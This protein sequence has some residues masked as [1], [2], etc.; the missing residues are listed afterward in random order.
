MRAE[1]KS[2]APTAG[3]RLDS[4]LVLLCEDLVASPGGLNLGLLEARLRRR[5]GNVSIRIASDLCRRPAAIGDCL[6]E[7]DASRLVLGWCSYSYSK[8]EVQGQMRRAGLDPL[9][10]Q[11]VP[12]A[13]TTAGEKP[14]IPS[15][16]RAALLLRAAIERARAFRPSRPENS[17]AVLLALDQPVSRRSLLTLPPVFYEAAPTI[18]G[19]ACTAADGCDQCVRTC[20]NDALRKDGASILVDRSRCRTCGVC[21]EACPQRA[22]ELPG[23]SAEEIEAQVFALLE[24]AT[25]PGSTEVAFVCEKATAAPDARSVPVPVPC[26]SMVPAA[27]MLHTL[28]RGASAIAM[29]GCGADCRNGLAEKVEGRVDYCQELLRSLGEPAQRIGVVST[30]DDARSQPAPS[31]SPAPATASENGGRFFGKGTAARE[32]RE[33]AG[34]YGITELVLQHPSSPLGLVDVN[35]DTCTAC[36]ACAV[37][38]PT[39]ALEYETNRGQSSL[40]F[41][42]SLCIA[43]NDCQA[44]CPERSRGAIACRAVT[45]LSR[46]AEGRQVIF[47]DDSVHCERC[48]SPFATRRMLDRLAEMLGDETGPEPVSRLCSDCRGTSF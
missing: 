30:T 16:R 10:V 3:A 21:V 8:F 13:G 44:L 36:G 22:V 15:E 20:P 4:T 28:A 12:L 24:G 43:C 34:H 42:A 9:G 19:E 35:P 14:G 37:V 6:E 32:V 7:G 48:G 45:D 5:V 47:R 39:G 25:A 40:S 18:N 41:D 26:L 33:L 1:T 46:I 31:P 29:Y 27:A 38:C 17:R 2:T 23:W 11:V